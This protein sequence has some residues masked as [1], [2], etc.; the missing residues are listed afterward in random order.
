LK[1]IEIIQLRNIKP[2]ILSHNK[3][4]WVFEDDLASQSA[5]ASSSYKCIQD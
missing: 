4:T 2:T 1:M 3:M 5:L